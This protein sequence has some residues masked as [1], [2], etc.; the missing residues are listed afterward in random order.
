MTCITSGDTLYAVRTS[1]Q[2]TSRFAARNGPL[3]S[4]LGFNSVE[5]AAHVFET[6]MRPTCGCVIFPTRVSLLHKENL[7]HVEIIGFRITNVLARLVTTPM[8]LNRRS[9]ARKLT[10]S[11]EIRDSANIVQIVQS[12]ET[13]EGASCVVSVAVGERVLPVSSAPERVIKLTVIPNV[14]RSRVSSEI[15]SSEI[16]HLSYLK[17]KFH[18]VQKMTGFSLNAGQ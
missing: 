8:R 12:A 7:V 15:G 4:R 5:N 9:G 13:G 3:L 16:Y 2:R 17:K 1:V 11:F 18:G 6:R 10:G 14:Y